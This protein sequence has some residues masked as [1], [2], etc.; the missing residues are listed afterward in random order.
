[1]D[2]WLT[3]NLAVVLMLAGVVPSILIVY[4]LYPQRNKPGVIWFLLAVVSGGVWALTFGIFTHITSPRWT[5]I[6]ANFFW[7]SIPFAAVSM[8]LLAYEFVFRRTV[9]RSTAVVVYLPVAVFF[10]LT[11]INPANL[12]FTDQYFVTSEG[13][14]HFPPFGGVIKVILMQ[15]YGY[16]LVFLA[17]G[18]FVGELLRARGLQR[19][20]TF[21]LFVM[22]ISLVIA[23][24]VKVMELVP[25]Y[26]DPTPTVFTLTGLMF[27]YSIYSHGSLRYVPTAREEAFENV[28][29]HILILNEDGVVIDAN[30]T[31]EEV[32]GT[33]VI[34]RHLN[35]MF[36]GSDPTIAKG[37]AGSVELEV[38]GRIRHFTARSSDFSFGRSAPG[39]ILSLSDTTEL[40]EREEELELLR[41]ILSRV[42]RHNIRNSIVVINGYV[43]LIKTH[44]GDEVG[45]FADEIHRK[46][47]HLLDQASKARMLEEVIEHESLA[48]QSLPAIVEQAL[49]AVEIDSSITVRTA[50]ADVR[51]PVHPNF[52]LAVQELIENTI[53]HREPDEHLDIDIYTE[54][55][56]P[57]V[58]LVVE[59]NGPGI[60]DAEV[61]VILSGRETDLE[62][63]SG[64][65]LWLVRWIVHRSNGE[66]DIDVSET[67]T[68]ISIS[69]L[70]AEEHSMRP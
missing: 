18:M 55:R 67:G 40:R 25:L 5:F 4:M 45:D 34:G 59:D 39:Q 60:P 70:A 35:E 52:H 24:M 31:G 1:M 19:K 58:S 9:S 38:D 51:T 29:D 53:E 20:Q 66:L 21:Y 11:W 15:G 65:G 13:H 27:A 49:S 57:R 30:T 64:I 3:P 12:I 47:D 7:A 8:F 37:V 6:I 36:Q 33:Q 44:G 23:S 16:L 22:F 42:L 62:H 69:L 32:F 28:E 41:T 56:G 46:S 10:C 48:T 17:A 61:E 68:R 50:V 43:E 2:T 63:S 14:L 54:E 26:F